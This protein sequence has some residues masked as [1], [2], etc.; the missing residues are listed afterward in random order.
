MNV[1]G[2]HRLSDWLVRGCGALE[3]GDEVRKENLGLLLVVLV[4]PLASA[5]LRQVRPLGPWLLMLG[6]LM[7]IGAALVSAFKRH[8]LGPFALWIEPSKYLSMKFTDGEIR[9]F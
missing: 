8:P 1:G 3:V 9:A 6:F 7:L 2:E 4:M 5:V